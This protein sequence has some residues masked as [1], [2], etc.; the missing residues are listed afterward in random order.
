MWKHQMDP[1]VKKRLEDLEAQM[2][3]FQQTADAI[4]AKLDELIA[5]RENPEKRSIEG[6]AKK[7]EPVPHGPGYTPWSKRKQQRAAQAAS[8]TF[9]DKVVKGAATTKPEETDAS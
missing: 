3:T 8:S 4:E 7:I 9:V 6:E 1:E 2:K 5:E